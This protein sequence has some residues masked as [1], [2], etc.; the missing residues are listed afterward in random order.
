[1]RESEREKRP[2]EVNRRSHGIVARS[3]SGTRSHGD[4]H[5]DDAASCAGGD[6]QCFDR[7][8]EV[9]GRIVHR[10][11]CHRAWAARLESRGGVGQTGLGRAAEHPRNDPHGEPAHPV[12]AVFA[13]AGESRADHEVGVVETR[14]ELRNGRRIVLSVGVDLDHDVVAVRE[15]VLEAEPHRAADSKVHREVGDDGSGGT[16]D[17]CG[18]VS[19]S[20]VHHEASGAGES[21]SDLGDDVTDRLPLVERGHDDEHTF[22]GMRHAEILSSEVWGG[23]ASPT[24]QCGVRRG[25]TRARCAMT[26][27][28]TRCEGRMLE[29]S[30]AASARL[31]TSSRNRPNCAVSGSGA[32]GIS[33]ISR[34]VCWRKLGRHRP[35][36]RIRADTP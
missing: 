34:I 19:R 12:R 20:V 28:I 36:L 22:E 9:L 30:S 32:G 15:R 23:A 5:L 29:R 8:A 11:E 17:R 26:W 16:R 6:H 10:E 24:M 7:V 4:R 3:A 31:S 2:R 18:V 33:G 1:M 21:V 13:F 27:S 35:M 25:Q 14:E